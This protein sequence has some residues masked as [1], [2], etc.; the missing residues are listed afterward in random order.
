MKFCNNEMCINVKIGYDNRIIEKV[1][2]TEFH[3]LQIDNNI[4]LKK[5]KQ[6]I[7]LKLSLSCFT[8]RKIKPVLKIDTLKLVYFACLHS[9]MSCGVTNV[10]E[11][12]NKC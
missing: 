6:S 1:G 4:L 11:K 5:N 2:S 8:M 9:V 12:F 10:Q 7:F 3:K